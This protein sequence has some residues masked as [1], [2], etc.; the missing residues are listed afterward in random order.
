MLAVANRP[1]DSSFDRAIEGRYPPGSTFKVVSAA[2]L[3][4]AGL[5][6]NESVDCPRALVVEGKLFRNFE[7]NAAGPVPFSQDFAQSC[8]TAF[9]SPHG[10]ARFPTRSPRAGRDYGL[11]PRLGGM[12]VPAPAAQVPPGRTAVERAAAMIGQH[13]LLASPLSM[14]GV[15]ATVSAG[16]WHAHAARI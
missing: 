4:R 9:V 11:G 2:A 7:G 6:T 10:P 1:I 3:L 15:A 5:D 13:E 14:A 12:P 8:N 16:R